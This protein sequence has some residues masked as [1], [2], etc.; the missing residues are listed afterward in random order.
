MELC[1]RLNGADTMGRVDRVLGCTDHLDTMTSG[2]TELVMFFAYGRRSPGPDVAPLGDAVSGGFDSE[3]S[4]ER[5]GRTETENPER[6][7]VRPMIQN[8]FSSS[9]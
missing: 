7:E 5:D 3:T 8:I 6:D 1:L 2:S 9:S 4:S